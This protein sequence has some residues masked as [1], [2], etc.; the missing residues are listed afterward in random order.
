MTWTS[1]VVIQPNPGDA[2]QT[3]VYF[4]HLVS[5]R[6]GIETAVYGF[7]GGPL[8]KAFDLPP[9]DEAN[10]MAMPPDFMPMF[11]PPPG[12]KSM[13]IQVTYKDGTQSPVREYKPTG[14]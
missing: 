4:T 6:C 13:Q 1:W 9:C 14:G 11:E 8:D 7:D 12:I 3:L 10:P 5:Y 2:S